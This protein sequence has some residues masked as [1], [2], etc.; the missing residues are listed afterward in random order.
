M[1]L[2]SAEAAE[3]RRKAATAPGNA[4]LKLGPTAWRFAA[5]LGVEYSSNLRLE[6]SDPKGDFSFSPSIEATMSWPVSEKNGLNLTLG[7][8]YQAYSRYTE[9]NRWF[10]TPGSQI[11]FDLY[12]GDFWVN[13]HDR[14]SITT[15]NYQDPTVVGSADYSQ[16]QNDAGV[17]VIWDLNKLIA[18]LGY[19]HLN[20]MVLTGGQGQ[21]DGRQEVFSLSGGY[22]LGGHA[23][24]GLELGGGLIHYDSSGTNTLYT[25]ATQWSVGPYFQS[26]LTDYMRLRAAAGYTA[27][28]PQESDL[29][30][31]SGMYAQLELS[32]RVNRFVDYALGGGRSIS[33]GFFGGTIDLYTA[34]LLAN[35]RVI[36]DFTLSTGFLY[37]HG[38]QLSVDQENFDRFGPSIAI[39]HRFVE[40][41]STSLSYQ[42]FSRLSDLPDR[43]YDAHIANLSIRYQF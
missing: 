14:F 9:Y 6:S 42:Y 30:E 20:Y 13:F 37:E 4:N 8:G 7:G 40:N 16:L 23:E 39:G 17:G 18:R 11:S 38:Q 33:F 28:T 22:L 3:A 32:H 34:R 21:P 12:A 41:L 29:S 1:S 31:F 35:W 26:Q 10:I 24:A 36:R 19:D 43:D 25:D 5:G 27:Y 2:A 15:D